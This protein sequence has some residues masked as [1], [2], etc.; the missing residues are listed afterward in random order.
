MSSRMDFGSFQGSCTDISLQCKQK[1]SYF[2]S[3]L[4][5]KI[6]DA[7]AL[8]QIN[9]HVGVSPLRGYSID[10]FLIPAN[11]YS[12]TCVDEKCLIS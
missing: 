7:N 1:L 11:V 4:V 8:I 5:C 6:I 10:R 12:V 9:K 2:Y 3:L